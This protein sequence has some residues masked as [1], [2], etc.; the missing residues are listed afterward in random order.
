MGV[1]NGISY[2]EHPRQGELVG[3]VVKV[4]FNYNADK[5]LKAICIRNDRESPGRTIF[6]L[7]DG[8]VLLAA[9][10][11]YTWDD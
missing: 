8:R 9:E 3:K 2:D 10:C 11:Q 7:H 6:R 1:V 4:C 5:Y